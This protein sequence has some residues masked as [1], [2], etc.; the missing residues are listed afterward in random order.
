VRL[1]R[2]WKS[3]KIISETVHIY[4]T[5]RILTLSNVTFFENVLNTPAFFIF[6]KIKRW[7]Q[8]LE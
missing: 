6:I 8:K 7:K 3:T 1:H 5:L 2:K 4:E